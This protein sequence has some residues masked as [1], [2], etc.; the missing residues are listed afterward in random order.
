MGSLLRLTGKQNEL[1][2][3]GVVW[4]ES[5]GENGIFGYRKGKKAYYRSK[6]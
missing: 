1:S 5:G 2:G 4:A 6:E 3:Q